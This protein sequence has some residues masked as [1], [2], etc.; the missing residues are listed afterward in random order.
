MLGKDA[1]KEYIR[2]LETNASLYNFLYN[3]YK[4]R[5]GSWKAQIKG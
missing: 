4:R 2:L 1:E 3:G 5:W